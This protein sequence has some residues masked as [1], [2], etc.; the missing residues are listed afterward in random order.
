ML[1]YSPVAA[2]N[3]TYAL[4]KCGRKAEAIK[5]AEKLQLT[6]NRFYHFL[7]A[8]LYI[9]ENIPI[10]IMHLEKARSLAKT[11]SEIQ[12]IENKLEMMNKA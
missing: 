6:N 3:R 1:E 4:A 5:E 12:L 8:E 10:A 2:L 9:N 7:L 11:N